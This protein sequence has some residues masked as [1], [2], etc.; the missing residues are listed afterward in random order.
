MSERTADAAAVASYIEDQHR[1]AVGQMTASDELDYLSTLHAIG[2]QVADLIAES[3]TIARSSG[4]SW[5]EIGRALGEMSKQAAWE[6][7]SRT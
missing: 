3:V 6:R 4:A 1:P 5:G 7:Y 2:G